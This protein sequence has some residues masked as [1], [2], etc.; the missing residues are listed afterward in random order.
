MNLGYVHIMHSFDL[1]PSVD[2]CCNVFET[3][4]WILGN[5]EFDYFVEEVDRRR[6]DRRVDKHNE[7]PVVCAKR[8]LYHG[9]GCNAKVYS[10]S[11]I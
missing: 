3:F 5:A 10:S 11:K 1:A 9:Y 8:I 6:S 7:H 2:R 4:L